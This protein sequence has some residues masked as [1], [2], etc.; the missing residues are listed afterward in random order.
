M[1]AAMAVRRAL[2]DVRGVRVSTARMAFGA[3]LALVLAGAPSAVTAGNGSAPLTPQVA[4]GLHEVELVVGDAAVD[5]IDALF[6]KYDP[7]YPEDFAAREHRFDALAERLFARTAR[8]QDNRCSQQIF[9]EAKWLLGYTAW[10]PRL[11]ARLDELEASFEVADQSFAAEPSPDDGFYGRCATELFIR[12][13]DTLV[14]YFELAARGEVPTVEREPLE[15]MRDPKKMTSF[16]ERHLISDI[17]ETGEDHRSRLGGIVSIIA[18]ADKRDPVIEMARSSVRGPDLTPERAAEMRAQ[19]N[20]LVD[21]WQDP[22]SGYWGAWYRDGERVFKTA[23]LSITYHV[24]HARRGEV[25]HWPE[26]IE[27]TFAI[28][29]QVYPFGWLSDGHWTDHNNYDLA[30][31]FRYAWPHMSDPQRQEAARSLQEMIDWSFEES[32][33][34]D[35]RGF[36][37]EPELSSSLGATFYFGASFLVAAGFFDSEPWYGAIEQPAPP[38]DVCLGMIDYGGTLDGPFAAGGLRKLE[39]ACEPHLQ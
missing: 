4:S 2:F 17:P 26:L 39:R 30:R 24:V 19:F 13:E 23:D 12:F 21:W 10:W 1:E 15:G 37:A 38:R 27:T 8:G 28:R 16:F 14:N 35:Y 22:E 32:V 29:E 5:R 3:V 25:R 6:L 36:R 33:Q 20:H 34:P 11:D 31:L 18:A 7:A 9:L